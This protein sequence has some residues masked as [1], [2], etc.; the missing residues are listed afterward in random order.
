MYFS[1]IVITHKRLPLLK[2]CLTSIERE[3]SLVSEIIVAVNGPDVE[4]Q[5]WLK[6]NS[7]FKTIALDSMSPAMAR[8]QAL[9]Q[10]QGTWCG[11]FD[12]DI[13][14]PVG[15]AKELTCL[16]TKSDVDVVGG[17]DQTPPNASAL[18]IIIGKA[19]TSPLSTSKT[20][21]RHTRDIAKVREADESDLI[22]CN[23]WMK[24]SI[25]RE[26]NFPENYFR[27]EENV[28]LY[29][30]HKQQ[31]KMLWSS[32][33]YVYH[34]RKSDLVSLYRA[35]SRSGECR[36][37]SLLNFDSNLDLRFL[38]PAIFVLYLIVLPLLFCWHPL[39][40]LGLFIY[41]IFD[42]IISISYAPTKFLA[43]M[44][45]QCCIIVFYGIGSWRELL[46]KS[47]S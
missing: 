47:S 20:R 18:E 28:L 12:D 35:V 43:L 25:L 7:K 19:L 17:P 36:I 37:R 31:R 22:L 38:L 32:N 8:N 27:N 39:W 14:L 23:L 1:I 13:T 26:N 30:L 41:L 9:L 2:Q 4:T 15:Y 16:L 44:Y 42:L 40:A 5:D 6:E 21:Y 24:T 45:I 29:Q 10:A 46:G 11:F 33:L 34:K 3:F